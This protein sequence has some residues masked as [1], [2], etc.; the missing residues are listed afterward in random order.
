MKLCK[1]VLV[2]FAAVIVFPVIV[3]AEGLTIGVVKLNDVFER[4]E[5]RTEMEESF[6]EL[7][8]REEELLMEKQDDLMALREEMQLLERGSE[9]RKELGVEMEKKALYLQL[10]EDVARK[11]LGEKEREYYEEL[12]Q[13][14]T[15]AIDEVGKEEGFDLILKK[16]EINPKSGDLMEL[17]LK[18]GMAAVLYFSESLDITDMV[19]EYLNERL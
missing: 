5:K 9:A 15:D 10:E 14:I 2:L 3:S 17:R 4:Y 8:A 12:F 7:K 16:E 6:K 18:I 1:Y 19:V 13:D 11:N